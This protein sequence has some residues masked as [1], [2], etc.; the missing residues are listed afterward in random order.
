[1]HTINYKVEELKEIDEV[2]SRAISEIL[3]MIS[4]LFTMLI[5]ISP[6]WSIHLYSDQ[7]QE[8]GKKQ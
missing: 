2:G 3:K 7:R 5:D 1:M 8:E 4:A 6:E